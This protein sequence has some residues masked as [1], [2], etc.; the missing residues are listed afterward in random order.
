M[1]DE[2]TFPFNPVKFIHY[3]LILASAPFCQMMTIT[4]LLT[5]TQL[6]LTS[7]GTVSY[8]DRLIDEWSASAQWCKVVAE[9]KQK[10]ERRKR[11]HPRDPSTPNKDETVAPNLIVGIVSSPPLKKVTNLLQNVER[12]EWISM[13]SLLILM[14]LWF[15]INIILV[16]SFS[17]QSLTSLQLSC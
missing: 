14:C 11:C 1:I 13:V 4:M 6:L 9:Q 17:P 5:P 7:L 16:P 3:I 12:M 2:L 10:N 15:S 8:S